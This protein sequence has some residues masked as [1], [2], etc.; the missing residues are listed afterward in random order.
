MMGDHS[1]TLPL[2]RAIEPASAQV[3][4]EAAVCAAAMMGDH[5][6]TLPLARAIEP[7]R[8][9]PFAKA[10]GIAPRPRKRGRGE[11]SDQGWKLRKAC[12]TAQRLPSLKR[13]QPV[14]SRFRSIMADSDV[15][16]LMQPTVFKYRSPSVTRYQPA[17]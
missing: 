1:L 17:L 8:A 12:S 13:S 2:A 6:L 14:P 10:R 3:F 9:Q 15:A 4:A 16:R 5:S 11:G 7:A